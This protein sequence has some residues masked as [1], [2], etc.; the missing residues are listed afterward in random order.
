MDRAGGV[1]RNDQWLVQIAIDQRQ[2]IAQRH[3]IE[4]Q[5]ALAPGQRCVVVIGLA[6]AGNE[7]AR[8]IIR[9]HRRPKAQTVAGKVIVAGDQ[10]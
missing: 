10:H 9:L 8:T 6:D 1:V 7:V 5:F 3:V 2:R 4:H